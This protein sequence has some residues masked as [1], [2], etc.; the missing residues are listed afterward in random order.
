M[1]FS[2][3]IPLYNKSYSIKRCI[4]SVLSQSYKNF[5]II[6]VN[7]GSTDDSIQKVT[8]GYSIE[9][10]LGRIRIINQ[11]N[12]GVSV[13]RNNGVADSNSEYVCFLDADDEWKPDF[14]E[15]M[16]FLIQEFPLASLYCLQHE[17]K[18]ETKPPVIN[19]SY[20]KKGFRG[21]V[22]NFFKASIFGSI[23][24]SSKVC[25]KKDSFLSLGGFP[26]NQKSGEDLYVWMELARKEKVVFYNSVSV[27]INLTKDNSRAG[28]SESIPYPFT[29]YSHPDNTYKLSSWSKIY[30]KKVYL[31][32][33]QESIKLNQFESAIVRAKSGVDLFPILSRSCIYI[34]SL[35]TNCKK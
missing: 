26:N 17:T 30:L 11:V 15:N 22:S 28:R 9:V 6:I 1:L 2:I 13:A 5:E 20:Y 7:D 34:L 8:E 33:L 23:A 4:D 16:H 12:K 29:Y 31:A 21:Y 27:R 24:N 3:V 19:S 14:L 18:L 32:H 25:I 35:K 10:F